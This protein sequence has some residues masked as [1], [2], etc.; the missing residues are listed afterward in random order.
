MSGHR[1]YKDSDYEGEFNLKLAERQLIMI[2]SNRY[3][4]NLYKMSLALEITLEQLNYKIVQ[5]KLE[6][7]EYNIQQKSNG[8]LSSKEGLR[9]KN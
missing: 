2:A 4:G 7:D 5:H 9:N 3:G 6:I 1:I 8:G